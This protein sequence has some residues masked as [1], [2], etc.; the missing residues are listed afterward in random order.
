MFSV[1]GELRRHSGFKLAATYV[2][3]TFSALFSGGAYGQGTLEEI[4]VT[5]RF[6]AESLQDVPLSITAISPEMIDSIGA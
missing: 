2:I 6:R 4:V 3:L 5:A 1:S